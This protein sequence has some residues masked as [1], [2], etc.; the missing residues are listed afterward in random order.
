MSRHPLTLPS[1]PSETTLVLLK[2]A[3]AMLDHA[4]SHGQTGSEVDGMI[5][6][7]GFDNVIEYLL[8]I[9]AT[10]LDIES[11]TGKKLDTPDLSKRTGNTGSMNTLTAKP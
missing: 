10:H 2:R 7:H 9:I 3:K 4:L 11:Q 6:L 1:S 5:A 8:R